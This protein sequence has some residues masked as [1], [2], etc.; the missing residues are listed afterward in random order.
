MSAGSRAERFLAAPVML[1]LLGG[2]C[3]AADEDAEQLRQEIAELRKELAEA[4]AENQRLRQE[5]DRLK[6]QQAGGGRGD[7]GA[8]APG[9]PAVQLLSF[10]A[11]RLSSL[12]MLAGGTTKLAGPVP[13]A[14]SVHLLP[15]VAMAGLKTVSIQS[16]GADAIDLSCRSRAGKAVTAACLTVRREGLFLT[17]KSLVATGLVE[18]LRL[19]EAVL[20]SS[21]I[22]VRSAGGTLAAYR[23]RPTVVE[24]SA[25]AAFGRANLSLLPGARL[26]A[27]DLADGWTA[28]AAEQNKLRMR[29]DSA[30]LLLVLDPAAGVLTTRWESIPSPKV[31]EIDQEIRNWQADVDELQKTLKSNPRN[32][33][34]IEKQIATNEKRIRELQQDRARLRGAVSAPRPTAEACKCEARV[35]LPNGVEMYRVKFTK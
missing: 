6:G 32:R 3:P 13:G 20:K 17:W 4:K 33:S 15:A 8:P 29:T 31:S 16:Q 10:P 9:E 26:V 24:F 7:D 18:A 27:G 25:A 2:V 28:E 5:I 23:F 12:G 34:E 30:G 22:E 14:A 19:L 11:L 35:V 1:A 21:T